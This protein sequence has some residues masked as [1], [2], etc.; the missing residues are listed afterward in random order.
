VLTVSFHKFGEYFP[1]TGDIR[2][3]GSGPG[4]YHAVNFPLKDG[5]DDQSYQNIFKPII[6][7]IMEIY[8]PGAIVLQCGADS[9]S[10]DRLGC[11][12]LSSKGHGQCVEFVSSFNVPLLVL[13]GGGYTIRNVARCWAYET[14]LLLDAELSEELPYN[15]Y[16]EYYGPDFR[17][18]IPQTNME[19]LNSKDYLERYK[20]KIL[21]NIRRIGKPNAASHERPPDILPNISEEDDEEFQDPDNR[22]NVRDLDNRIH[23]NDEYSDSEEEDER[24]NIQVDEEDRVQITHGGPRSSIST[25]QHEKTFSSNNGNLQNSIASSAIALSTAFEKMEVETSNPQ[26]SSSTASPEVSV[27]PDTEQK[28]KPM[29][30]SSSNNA[31]WHWE[32]TSGMEQH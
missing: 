19:N 3:I 22:R 31:S 14:A 10:G 32:E 20:Q 30:A 9:L 8:Q 11:F 4:K 21:E 15:D 23:R 28:D 12:N 24:R 5:I 7:T 16:I 1:G 26:P 18:H 29:V 2:D 13:G 17:L 25:Q 27:P 6:Q